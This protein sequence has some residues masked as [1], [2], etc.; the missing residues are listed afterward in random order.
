MKDKVYI[1]GFL[2]DIVLQLI[3]DNDKM[4]GY[5]ITQKVKQ[6]TAGEIKLT[7]G[8]LY[9]V[10]HKLESKGLLTASFDKVD[11]RTRKYYEL[12]VEGGEKSKKSIAELQNFIGN[13]QTLFNLK[14]V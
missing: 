13:L 5:E 12:T 8:A 3:R 1:K 2:E 10:L 9:P 7:E 4:Y 6:L 11:G 14:P